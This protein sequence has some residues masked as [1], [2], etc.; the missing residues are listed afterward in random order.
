MRCVGSLPHLRVTRSAAHSLGLVTRLCCVHGAS[1]LPSPT[2]GVPVP[3][4]CLAGPAPSLY[5]LPRTEHG[6]PAHHRDQPKALQ[7]P[8]KATGACEHTLC[9]ARPV[10]LLAFNPISLARASQRMMWICRCPLV[11]PA[12]LVL[13][14]SVFL[15][16][17]WSAKL[18]FIRACASRSQFKAISST[19]ASAS[20]FSC[21]RAC[22]PS[23]PSPPNA[24][25]PRAV[26]PIA[27][28]HFPTPTAPMGV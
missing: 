5:H 25:H 27:T 20:H 16:I 18:N 3:C 17:L 11:G 8:Q 10:P 22:S 6:T 7:R 9:R 13:H 1:R 4:R 21:G 12:L 19:S 23:F 14:Q 24:P 26:H 2:L 15:A 28:H